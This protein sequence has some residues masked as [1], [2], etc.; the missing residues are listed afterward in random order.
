M[1]INTLLLLSS[2]PFLKK[3]NTKKNNQS[4][5]PTKTDGNPPKKETIEPDTVI[6]ILLRNRFA[7]SMS[8]RSHS[9]KPAVEYFAFV[10]S[11]EIYKQSVGAE[12][13]PRRHRF[14]CL[15]A[16]ITLKDDDD[17]DG[18]KVLDVKA[19]VG[20]PRVSS[21]P[22]FKAFGP[23]WR[24]GLGLSSL[25]GDRGGKVEEESEK[26]R[27]GW[28][29]GG[30]GLWP[31]TL[32]SNQFHCALPSLWPTI[33]TTA[34]TLGVFVTHGISCMCTP[35]LVWKSVSTLH[36]Q[37]SEALWAHSHFLSQWGN[38][39]KGRTRSH[40]PIRESFI[41]THNWLALVSQSFDKKTVTQNWDNTHA[42]SQS[43]HPG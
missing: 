7:P 12:L 6:Y 23:I 18:P 8:T 4:K 28:E 1:N 21:S 22:F 25:W 27:W 34:E 29:K 17:D 43:S 13:S 2:F 37:C 42:Y 24:F 5:Q 40:R 16:R 41:H 20:R 31:M 32:E 10:S 30:W 38:E 26:G 33:H 14:S 39:E 3:H 15:L 9:W 36:H 35:L 19:S 11:R